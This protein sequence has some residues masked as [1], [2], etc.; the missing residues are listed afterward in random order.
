M[1]DKLP[2][3]NTAEFMQSW[4]Q[5]TIANAGMNTAATGLENFKKTVGER[6]KINI[7]QKCTA[8]LLRERSINFQSPK[9]SLL[10][11]RIG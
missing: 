3:T 9:K 8:L 1:L 4:Q 2:A 5:T 7:S 10:Q 11:T 6:N